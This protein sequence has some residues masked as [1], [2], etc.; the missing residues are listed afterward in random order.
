[1]SRPLNLHH[2]PGWRRPAAILVAALAGFSLAAFAAIAVAKTFTLKVV[3]NVHVTNTPTKAFRVR[4]VDVHEAVAVGPAGFPVY[5][6]QGE[7]TH[8]LICMKTTKPSTNC[9]AFWP[10]V[11]VK[12]A[13]GLSAQSG[14]KGK[15]GTF[16]NHGTLQLTLG[17]KPLYY[18]T[19]DIKSGNKHLATGDELKTFGSIWHIVTA[20]KSGTGLSQSTSTSTQPTTTN[21]YGM[22]Y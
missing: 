5:T 21:P 19:P 8:H 7:T 6:F 4:A 3:K 13:K 18:F 22:G 9:W 10:P 15:L 2:A 1:M 20:S 17:G 11:A 12:S 14:I 16:H